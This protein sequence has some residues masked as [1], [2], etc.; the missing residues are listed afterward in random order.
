MNTDQMVFL[1]F[2]PILLDWETLN[3]KLNPKDN[4]KI[5]RT[6]MK[7]ISLPAL[8]YLGVYLTDLV[9]AETSTSTR[10]DSGYEFFFFFFF[11]KKN[12]N[13]K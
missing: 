7:E 5:Y 12:W 9:Y 1:F 4:Y 10:L 2:F 8:P 3:A 6:T 11:K 13:Q